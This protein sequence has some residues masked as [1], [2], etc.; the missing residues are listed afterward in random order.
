M[1]KRSRAKASKK[2]KRDFLPVLPTLLKN[3]IKWKS[4]DKCSLHH[5][6]FVFP[7]L[8]TYFLFI[9]GWCKS[10]AAI[11]FSFSYFEKLEKD[12]TIADGVQCEV[13]SS[14]VLQQ[15]T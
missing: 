3:K 4:F 6:W 14:Y 9:A 13:N 8:H 2:L 5:F 10:Y 15:L 11:A 12:K 7:F 1:S